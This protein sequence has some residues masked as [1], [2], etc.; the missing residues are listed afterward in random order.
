MFI[1]LEPT[2]QSKLRGSGMETSSLS[3]PLLRS[4][5]SEKTGFAIDI[6]HLTALS[7]RRCV[8]LAWLFNKA[9]WLLVK[10][11]LKKCEKNIDIVFCS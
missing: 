9:R 10:I 1:G 5:A 8:G 6:S 3:V 2:N 4:W 7:I 11:I